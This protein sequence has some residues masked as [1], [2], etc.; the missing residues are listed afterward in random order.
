PASPPTNTRRPS[1]RDAAA[2]WPFSSS[3]RSSRSSSAWSPMG[4]GDYS[5]SLRG[6]RAARGGGD[7][8][9]S[10]PMAG[11]GRRRLSARA[12]NRAT[13]ARQLLLAREPLPAAEGV[14]RVLALQAQEPVGPYLALTAR[15]EGF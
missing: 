11:G 8:L 3:R 10:G 7:A 2:A 1:P 9:P 12:L 5:G 6:P 15:L 4:T 14:R 13:L